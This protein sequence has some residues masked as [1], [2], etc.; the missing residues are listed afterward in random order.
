ML[1]FCSRWGD[2]VP[3]TDRELPVILASCDYGYKMARSVNFLASIVKEY[4]CLVD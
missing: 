3:T 1:I 4:R 2:R